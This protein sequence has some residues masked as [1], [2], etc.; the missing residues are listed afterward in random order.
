MNNKLITDCETVKN[1]RI[2]NLLIEAYK[3]IYL[4]AVARNFL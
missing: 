3:I 1:G 2:N 4:L